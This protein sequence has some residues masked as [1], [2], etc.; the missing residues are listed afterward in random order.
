MQNS[1]RDHP[2]IV[3]LPDRERTTYVWLR[4]GR[5]GTVGDSRVSR[6][7]GRIEVDRIALDAASIA[8]FEPGLLDGQPL[9]TWVSLPFVVGSH[10]QPAGN[11]HV[12]PGTAP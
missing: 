2:A 3:K 12:P 1:L 7:S 9:E 8:T 4:V 10:G 6:T 5:D 11:S